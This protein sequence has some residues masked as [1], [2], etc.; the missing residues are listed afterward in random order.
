MLNPY[1][2]PGI[3]D[4]PDLDKALSPEDKK[5]VARLTVRE[6]QRPPEASS[7]QPETQSARLIA[8][9]S[10]VAVAA[11]ASVDAP[12]PDMAS[13]YLDMR[14]P[15]VATNGERP[16][17]GTVTRLSWGFCLAAVMA[18]LPWVALNTLALPVAVSLLS[19]VVPDAPAP[20]AER[21]VAPLA[22]LIVIGVIASIVFT[23]LVSALS[24]RTR[25]SIGRRTPWIVSG[26]ILCALLTLILGVD[27]NLATAAILWVAMQFG[28]AALSVPLASEISER[29]PDKFRPRI[30]RWHGIGVMLGQAL[31][32]IVGALFVMDLSYALFDVIALAFAVSGI[33]AVLVLPKEPSS[34]EQPH[35][36]LT[37]GQVVAS[38]RPPVGASGFAGM[39]VAR[40][41]MMAALGLTSV[42]LWYLVRYWV[43]GEAVLF[44]SAPRTVPAGVLIAGMAVATLAGAA[45]ASWVAGPI[46]DWA[47]AKAVDA[48]LLV[49]ASCVLYGIG[50]ALAWGLGVWSAGAAREIGLVLFSL[51][52]GLAFGLYDTFGLGLVMAV[53]P[54]PRTAGHDLGFY[55]I[56]NALGLAVAAILGAALVS[57]FAQSFGYM[58]LF[59]AAIVMVAAAGVLTV[60]VKRA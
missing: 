48:S 34:E 43:Y 37:W 6:R 23:P 19:G 7:E 3:D 17:A 42:F 57:A 50:L 22:L 27:N 21:L 60:T 45:L 30:E 11:A 36:A 33:V 29:V 9:G 20:S 10:S 18:G 12:A 26:G 44:T 49:V 14:D 54:N 53:L 56:A 51:I 4:R 47:E 31:G 24:D 59:P 25:V 40:V 32:I 15:M 41:C 5:A 35:Q 38:L 52:S 16:T 28:Y 46:S 55:A 58:V 1:V 13:A 2:R 39:F 8:S